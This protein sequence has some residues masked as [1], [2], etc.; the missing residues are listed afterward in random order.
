MR[1]I[2][3]FCYPKM[4]SVHSQ[5]IVEPMSYPTAPYTANGKI[6]FGKIRYKVTKN[7]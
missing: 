6:H 1:Q 7:F 4:V 5:S 2:G 3:A